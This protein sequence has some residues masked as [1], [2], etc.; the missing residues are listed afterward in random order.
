MSIDNVIG[1]AILQCGQIQSE[2]PDPQCVTLNEVP[3]TAVRGHVGDGHSAT[4]FVEKLAAGGVLEVIDMET[5]V[6]WR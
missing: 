5:Q 6:S 4:I 1:N 3:F 2:C